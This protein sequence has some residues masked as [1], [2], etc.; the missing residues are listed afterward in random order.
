MLGA[1]FREVHQA[2]GCKIHL[3]GP[4]LLT[5]P[6]PSPLHDPD[7]GSGWTPSGG[8]LIHAR[9]MSGVNFLP[10]V[11]AFIFNFLLVLGPRLVVLRADSWLCAQ[12]SFLEVLWRTY[13]MLGLNLGLSCERQVLYQLYYLFVLDF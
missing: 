3:P 8:A 12:G 11:G 9:P 5:T 6:L 13:V 7:R 4:L 2:T 1:V 10:T